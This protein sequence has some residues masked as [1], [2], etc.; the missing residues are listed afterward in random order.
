[1]PKLFHPIRQWNG[2][3][4][5][6]S[7]ISSRNGSRNGTKPSQVS[8]TDGTHDNSIIATKSWRVWH[9]PDSNAKSFRDASSESTERLELGQVNGFRTVHVSN[10]QGFGPRP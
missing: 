10:G 6:S 3:S 7:L 9:G 1:M 2:W 8:M 5:I 4:K